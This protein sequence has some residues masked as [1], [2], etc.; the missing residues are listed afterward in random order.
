MESTSPTPYHR[1]LT[2]TG[3]GWRAVVCAV[4]GLAGLALLPVVSFLAV[5][6]G[7]FVLGYDDFELNLDDG[8]NAGEILGTNLG[9]ALL[10]PYS[11]FLARVLYGV[12][13]RWVSSA[14][15]GLRGRWLLICIGIAAAVQGLLLV[16][17][18][19]GVAS[20]R[21]SAL[22]SAVW[23]MLLVVVLTTPLQATG[24]EYLFRGVLLQGLGATRL[25]TWA[26]CLASGLLFATAHLQFAPEL[27]ADRLLLGVVFAYLAIKTGGLEAPIAIHAVK[28]LVVLIPAALLEETEDAIDPTGVTWI[29]FIVDVVLLAILVPWILRAYRKRRDELGPREP[30]GPGGAPRIPPATWSP[31]AGTPMPWSAGPRPVPPGAPPAPPPSG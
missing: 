6:A 28:N 3:A 7:A 12:R 22:D 23:W 30:L 25:P 19:A 4:M 11:F 10:I 24:E 9:L 29:P 2:R 26:C 31:P 1:L 15:P 5:Y 8:V 13:P 18:L 21:E 14:R 17:G 16:L 20:E 27:F